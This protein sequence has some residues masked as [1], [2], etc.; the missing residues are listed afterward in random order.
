[1]PQ[2]HLMKVLV[3]GATGLLGPYL[4]DAASNFG[5]V[6]TV[7]HDKGER[8]VDLTDLAACR[9]L[10]AVTAPDIVLHAAAKTDVDQ[11]ERDPE[12]ADRVNRGA[13]ANL[14]ASLPPNIK[15]VYLS[16][17]QVYPD[18]P[19][20][21]RENDEAPVNIYGRSKLEGEHA[22]LTHPR[23]LVVRTNLFGPSRT[24]GRRSLSDFIVDQLSANLPTTL[25]EDVQFSP[26]HMGTLADLI[27][28]LVRHD[29]SGVFNLGSRGGMSKSKFGLRIANQLDLP[30][31]SVMI[32]HSTSVP[33]R[34]KRP[35]DLRLD[36]SRVESAL[37]REMPTLEEEIARL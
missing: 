35:A 31:K 15:L 4:T 20:P 6:V 10:V 3:T 11:C 26:L 37:N 32:G 27:M 14:A 8:R 19:G 22:V 30:T 29:V 7:G 25:F 28:E 2:S 13:A 24:F 5:S 17:D 36:V 23:A 1:L 12:Q 34:A 33:G 16:T 21:H 9:S 18:L